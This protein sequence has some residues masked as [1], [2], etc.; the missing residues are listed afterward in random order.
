MN[1]ARH[2]NDSH[3]ALQ[4]MSINKRLLTPYCCTIV[5][6]LLLLPTRAYCAELKSHDFFTFT[7]E[8]D[9]FVAEDNGYTN[10]MALSFGHGPFENFSAEHMPQWLFWLTEDLYISTM[11]GKHRGIAHAIFQ[12]MQTPENLSRSELIEDDVP[13]VG[14]LGWQCSLHA[15]DD[16]VSDQFSIQL[17]LVG[18]VSLADKTQT[19]VHAA[20]GADK[21]RGW[22]NQIDN[23][24]A[25][26]IEAQRAWR[27]YQKQGDAL[28]YDIIGILSGG[29]GTLE[30]SATA[31]LAIRWGNNIMAGFP[32]FSLQADRQINPLSLS[33]KSDYYF[34]AG[35]GV[36]YIYNNIM[37]NGNTFTDSHHLPLE[38]F[39][40]ELSA[41]LVWSTGAQV[42]FVFQISSSSP[43]STISN[44]RENY[45]ALSVT[46]SY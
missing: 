38:H 30:S 37:I 13:Y 42:S 33:Q 10:G 2:D 44:K 15:W 24:L 5:I 4:L 35:I 45:G 28:D 19:L 1:I 23:E 36:T 8:N 12:G 31:E 18:P 9:F 22:D 25:F 46:Y 34:F 21:P 29:I 16:Q 26:R 27:L 11:P 41:G 40:N 17:G 7:F 43:R 32:T 3:K 20:F 14:L 6:L 39:F